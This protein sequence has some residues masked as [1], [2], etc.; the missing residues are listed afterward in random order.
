M[1]HEPPHAS[2][3]TSRPM[4][5]RSA[6][7]STRT[8][9]STPLPSSPKIESS[10]V[11]SPSSE[12]GY[13][14]RERHWT[15]LS[16]ENASPL[17]PRPATP[18]DPEGAHAA[19]MIHTLA[20]A[21]T[22][23]R[24]FEKR[25]PWPS[26]HD[27]SSEQSSPSSSVTSNSS[28][29]DSTDSY[30]AER[31]DSPVSASSFNVSLDRPVSPRT[32]SNDDEEVRVRSSWSPKQRVQLPTSILGKH[33]RAEDFYEEKSSELQ[34][35]CDDDDQ[36]IDGIVYTDSMVYKVFEVPQGS[37]K[38]DL[39]I[40]FNKKNVKLEILKIDVTNDQEDYRKFAEP[41]SN[42]QIQWRCIYPTF[43]AGEPGLCNYTAQRNMVRR[44]VESTHLKIKRF[45]CSW[46]G[47]KFTQ[48]S[49]AE[50]AHVNLQ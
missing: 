10:L 22:L 48:R 28:R 18:E 4:L 11:N 38:P 7:H 25:S 9:S 23:M 44:H 34:S 33:A 41:I 12:A 49:N 40:Y 29:V 45:Q 21:S 17:N 30:A 24:R 50:R 8:R 42:D 36:E 13:H 39:K 19:L 27:R 43:H 14:G 6:G 5:L 15:S 32:A 3:S 31:E 20:A 37:G 26:S 46:C 16:D 1:T 35:Y 2:V 47:S